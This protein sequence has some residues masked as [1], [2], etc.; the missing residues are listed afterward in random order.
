MPTVNKSS[1]MPK[2]AIAEGNVSEDRTSTVKKKMKVN[3]HSKYIARSPNA[4]YCRMASEMR[5]C[6]GGK[7]G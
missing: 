5:K 3:K 1:A 4:I 7:V 2:F 6:G